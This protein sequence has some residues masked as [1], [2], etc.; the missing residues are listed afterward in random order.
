MKK[1]ALFS[2]LFIALMS[3]SGCAGKES[4]VPVY[5][6]VSNQPAA[7]SYLPDLL[8]AAVVCALKGNLL[9]VKI[10]NN[11]REFTLAGVDFPKIY[12]PYS[13]PQSQDEN[14]FKYITSL[15]GSTVY[16]EADNS[17]GSGALE[18][19]IYTAKPVEISDQEIRDKMLNARLILMGYAKTPLDKDFK[20]ANYF[21]E[22]ESEARNHR[23]GIWDKGPVIEEEPCLDETGNTTST[24]SETVS[25][26]KTV[27]TIK[28]KD[29]ETVTKDFDWQYNGSS[30]RWRV[31]VPQSLIAW[32]KKI[33]DT[34]SKFYNS[35][36][37]TQNQLLLKLNEDEKVLLAAYSTE[38]KGSFVPWVTEEQ[39]NRF[40]EILGEKLL[41]RAQADG[42]DDYQTADFVLSFVCEAIMYSAADMRLPAQTFADNGD[43]DCKALLFASILKNMG[44][45]VS[46]LVSGQH[47]AVGV[48]FE[49]SPEGNDF[50]NFEYKGKKYYIA[51]TATP[52]WHIGEKGDSPSWENTACYPVS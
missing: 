39:N 3:L 33:S 52:G 30:Y 32:D 13:P 27:G 5:R 22:C 51:E 37:S 18:G 40:T 20:Y 31:E 2:I 1:T 21:L 42:F 50:S 14:A 45:N 11:E 23:T 41:A 43:G 6:P 29:V 47:L 28:F 10:N 15:K 8:Q 35:D 38:S 4:G 44:Y 34:C 36:G 17:S 46:L 49:Q 7:K 9:I 12:T 24:P 48:A 16:L 19:Y 26:Y 25:N